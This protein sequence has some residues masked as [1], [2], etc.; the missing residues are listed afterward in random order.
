[1]VDIDT[2]DFETRLAIIQQKAREKSL[3]CHKKWQSISP[4]ILAEMCEK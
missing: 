2:P 1:M 4:I 3:S